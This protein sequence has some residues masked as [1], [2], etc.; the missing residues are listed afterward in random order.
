MIVSTLA[1]MKIDRLQTCGP[2]NGS[3]S[4]KTIL[5]PD[6]WNQTACFQ[7]LSSSNTQLFSFLFISYI[8]WV[9]YPFSFLTSYTVCV[10]YP[11]L[12]LIKKKSSTLFV[13]IICFLL[14]SY[15][16]CVHYLFPS[17]LLHIIC[18][19]LISY[20]VCVHYLFP[21]QLLHCLCALSI[22]F[23]V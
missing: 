4:L 10:R 3:R 6:H 5:G 9:R 7:S 1:A 21:S 15:N 11:F 20:I 22:L 23:V 12:F 18:F 16:V 13:Y 14:I 2:E 8:V 19:L 17:H